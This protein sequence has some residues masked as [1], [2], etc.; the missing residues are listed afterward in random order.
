M[1]A[2]LVFVAALLYIMFSTAFSN[3]LTPQGE[4]V[5]VPSV[6][7]RLFTEAQADTELLNGFTL[8]QISQE[9]SSQP[10]GTIIRQSPDGNSLISG[11]NR[12]IQVVVSSGAAEEILMPDLVNKTLSQALGA[13]DAL[14][15]DLDVDYRSQSD[16]HD[17]IPEN[18]VI[19]TYPEKDQPLSEGQRVILKLSLGPEAPKTTVMSLVVGMTE[20]SAIKAITDLGLVVGQ[21]ERLP[22]D[23]QPEGRVWY[24]SVAINTE[25]P[26]GTSV[27]IFVSTGSSGES[28][29][30][31]DTGEQETVT[32]FISFTL[33]TDRGD[34]LQVDVVDSEDNTVHQGQYDINLD[35][36]TESFPVTGTGRETYTCYINGSQ[37]SQ[38]VVDFG[39]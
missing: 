8:E 15:L 30:G 22:S 25:V 36:A 1:A 9:E 6:E 21:V 12:V 7:G 24:Q 27:D 28:S 3:T 17:T 20:E 13:L 2:I 34:V 32:K 39:A 10:E 18:S 31:G 16:Y 37:Y 5:R 4:T 29:G 38:Q 26:L 23:E 11:D 33:P 14:D 19:S 35:T